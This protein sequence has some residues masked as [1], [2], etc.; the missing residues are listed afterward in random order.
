M[1]DIHQISNSYYLGI[2]G[3]HNLV[4]TFHAARKWKYSEKFSK[5][6][7][8]THTLKAELMILCFLSLTFNFIVLW[9]WIETAWAIIAS[10]VL[11]T[12]C[13]ELHG[14]QFLVPEILAINPKLL[15]IWIRFSWAYK[16]HTG[17]VS[18]RGLLRASWISF[19]LW[20]DQNKIIPMK[21]GSNKCII[22]IV[23]LRAN[24]YNAAGK[25]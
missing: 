21:Q 10:R 25:L 2:Y 11:I 1:N 13:S 15:W 5:F 3:T 17:A 18:K 22:I 7:F 19:L 4:M 24:N 6:Y 12:F 14:F 8:D 23:F 9:S 16:T 20:K